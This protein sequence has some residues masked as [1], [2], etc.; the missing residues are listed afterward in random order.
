MKGNNL[1]TPSGVKDYL[2]ND[3]KLK[4]K[5][6]ESILNVFNGYGYKQISSPTF[7]FNEVFANTG[8][9]KESR[10]YRLL[11]RD[12]ALLVLRPDMTPAIARIAATAFNKEMS[13]LKFS[14]VENMFR[15]NENYQGKLREFTQAG[16]ELIGAN[17]IE[18][19]IEVILAAINSIL[20]VGI[21]DFVIDI[22][23]TMFLKGVI[24]EANISDELATDIQK[25]LA[26]KNYV[27]VSELAENISN[28]NIKYIFKELPFLIGEI[29]IINK[30]KNL[31]TNKDALN[32]LDYLYQLY[33]ILDSLGYSKYITFDF[34][35]MGSMDYY[36]GL[37]FRGYARGAG[38]SIVDGGR[39]D[40]M[41]ERFGAKKAAVG[42]SIKINELMSLFKT[43]EIEGTDLLVVCSKPNKIDAYKL[44]HDL[45]LKNYSVE[46]S[47][48]G[49]D[50]DTNLAYAKD[51]GIDYIINYT[52]EKIMKIN[53]IT[54]KSEEYSE[55]LDKEV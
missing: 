1:H 5:I 9:I 35:V 46:M 40:N 37:I 32:A 53:V 6:E 26:D 50:L 28:D 18:A 16:I 33:N 47:F 55:L 30:L 12:G 10:T 4:N 31:V 3:C 43:D 20:V 2:Y 15:A 38:L 45:R 14:Y 51:K 29:N 54:G 24:E 17:S 19:D 48:L 42:F 23:H 25:S 34:G 39:Y 22:G 21:T 13:I 49:D 8:G 52:D 36:T 44:A 11:D 7:E 41:V 27:A